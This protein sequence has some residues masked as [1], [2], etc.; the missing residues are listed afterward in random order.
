[1]DQLGLILNPLRLK[2]SAEVFII[3]DLANPLMEVGLKRPYR[4]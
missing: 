2:V 4:N 1:M 3:G